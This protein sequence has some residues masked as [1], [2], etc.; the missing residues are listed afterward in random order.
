MSDLVTCQNSDILGTH[1]L[2]WLYSHVIG[3]GLL[4][5]DSQL[6]QLSCQDW[7]IQ[8]ATSFRTSV[9]PFVLEVTESPLIPFVEIALWRGGG[10][11]FQ[12]S[13]SAVLGIT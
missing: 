2:S 5:G 6:P 7:E 10:L 9:L 12:S 13:E 4:P 11:C 3:S 1:T 8:V